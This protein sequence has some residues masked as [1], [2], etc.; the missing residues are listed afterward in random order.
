MAHVLVMPKQGNTVES[1]VLVSWKVAEGAAVAAE[2][3]ICEVETDKATFEVPAGAA[4]VVLKLLRA[5]GDDV[6]VMEPIAVVGKQGEDWSAAVG[7][8]AAPAPAAA[9]ASAASAPQQAAA[10]AA[11]AAAPAA[12]EA[13]PQRG[14]SPRARRLAREEGLST[15]G[16][17]GTGPGGRVIERDVRAALEAQPPLTAAARAA[18]AAGAQVP[19]SG[20]ALG[21][22][23]GLA[24][25]AA[26]AGAAPAAAVPAGDG[27]YTETPVKSIRKIIAERMRASLGTTAQVSFHGSAPAARLSA[28]R[29]RFKAADPALGL[30]E[31]TIGDLVTYAVSRVVP[32][33][34]ALNSH[35]V[36]GTLR[37]FQRVNLGFAVDTPRGLLV[38]VLRNADRLSLAAISAESK[39]LAAAC[40]GGTIKPDELT[41]ATFTVSNLGAFGV[42]AFTPVLNAPEVGILGVCAIMPRPALAKDGT[43]SVEQRI[44]LSLTADH[45]VID[46]APAARIL[47]A[48]CDA[49]AEIDLLW[50]R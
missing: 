45:Q 3:V 29:A 2:Q 48:F 31:I 27:G 9:P 34:P 5:A 4:G 50:T 11:V 21:G 47:K 38:P 35:L 15:A 13:G 26:G 28:L 30:S 46:G 41:G 43:V 36:N 10:P 6:P 23:V 14:V 17:P 19:A 25:L 42:E 32:K 40:Q 8:G 18:A 24:D 20:G 1:C 49:I 37:T 33:F 39:R 7:G 12:A 22:R 44:G 16:L